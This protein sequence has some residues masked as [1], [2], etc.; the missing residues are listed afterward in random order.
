MNCVS[1]KT[2]WVGYY[3][4]QILISFKDTVL[5]FIPRWLPLRLP[6][7]PTHQTSYSLMLND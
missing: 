4:M 5:S 3:V 7:V 6:E 1:S 2:G